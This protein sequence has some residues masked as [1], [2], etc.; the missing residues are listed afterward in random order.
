MND[1]EG[2]SMQRLSAHARGF[3]DR[4]ALN[5]VW[6][7]F[8]SYLRVFAKFFQL[9]ATKL[10]PEGARLLRVCYARFPMAPASVAFV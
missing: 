2:S 6:S 9:H 3:G 7:R 5:D 1:V 10:H 4:N 8:A